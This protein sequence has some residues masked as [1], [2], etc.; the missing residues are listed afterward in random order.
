M[1]VRIRFQ[2]FD[3]KLKCNLRSYVLQVTLAAV[4]LLLI[5]WLENPLTRAALIAAI[6]STAFVLFITP[7]SRSAAPRHVVGGHLIGLVIGSMAGSFG[8][9]A[10]QEFLCA[11]QAA[12]AVGAAMFLMAAIDTEHAPGRARRWA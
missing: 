3:P 1:L 11:L 9:D 8:A 6:G 10:G 5:L 12:S 4:A 7:D 2:I